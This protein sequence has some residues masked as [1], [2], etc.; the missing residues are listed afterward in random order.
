[1]QPLQID[2][3]LTGPWCPPAYGMHLDSVLAYSLVNRC[4][5][6]AN[7]MVS[8]YE[9]IIADLPLERHENGV[10]KASVFHPVGWLGQER[11]CLVAKTDVEH[12]SCLIARGTVESKGGSKIDTVRGIAK[13][14][15]TFFTIEHAQGLRAW[16]IG[17]A[18]A[19]SELLSDVFAVGVKTRIGFGSLLP[20]PGGELWRVSE[21]EEASVHWMRRSSPT[22]LIQESYPAVGSWHAPYWRGNVPIFRPFPTRLPA[23]ES[24][25]NSQS[26]TIEEV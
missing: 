17:D 20:Y 7:S 6:A 25:G 1:M 15:Q 13:N 12:M 16:C 14:A 10:W 4:V 22:R 11:R 2:C 5:R 26:M 23:Q 8:S 3:L 18:D 24:S 9:E 19:V 21:C